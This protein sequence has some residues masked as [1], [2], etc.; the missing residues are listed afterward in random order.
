M[1]LYVSVSIYIIRRCAC[2]RYNIRL[3]LHYAWWR[4]GSA[5]S[6]CGDA[7]IRH[8]NRPK[9]HESRNRDRR[10]TE[11]LRARMEKRTSISDYRRHYPK[12]TVVVFAGFIHLFRPY[13]I[14]LFHLRMPFPF[15]CSF[16]FWC[17]PCVRVSFYFCCFSVRIHNSHVQMC[18]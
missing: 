7:H 14:S 2:V 3:I 8:K 6:L 18:K 9:K 4:Y 12:W 11:R 13:F 5:V 1:Q 15:D 16:S 17:V 10:R